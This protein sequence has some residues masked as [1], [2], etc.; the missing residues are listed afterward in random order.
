[1]VFN[2]HEL[3]VAVAVKYGA[4]KA[5]V[6]QQI[7]SWINYNKANNQNFYDGK[8]WTYNSVEAWTKL[9]PYFSY[10]QM[11][12]ILRDL[13]SDGL[14]EK[15]KYNKTSMDKTSWYT[16]TDKG[17]AELSAS[18][19]ICEKTQIDLCKNTDASV[20]LHDSSCEKTQS[21]T[22]NKTIIKNTSIKKD[23]SSVPS[24]ISKEKEDK[25]KRFSGVN[26][27][28]E[29]VEAYIREKNFHVSAQ[30]ITDYYT[31]DGKFDVWRFPNKP[32][33]PP[34]LVKDWKGCVRTFEDNWKE[35]NR[36]SVQKKRSEASEREREQLRA[37]MRSLGEQRNAANQ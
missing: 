35:K 18:Y 31:K 23:I 32:G 21:N 34:P 20:E 19:T 11:R 29:E 12:K 30:R 14:I 15:G 27:S 16:I 37:Y 3:N 26:P 28:I 5:L 13:E 17:Y 36:Y 9:I 24:D 25:P 22:I 8:F 10:E 7:N 1:M 2:T 6:L 4:T 33:N